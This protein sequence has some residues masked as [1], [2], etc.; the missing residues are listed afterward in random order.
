VHASR[1]SEHTTLIERCIDDS[2]NAIVVASILP[3]FQRPDILGISL[4][5]HHQEETP[6]GWMR[7]HISARA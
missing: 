5:V 7:L 3:P 4:T 6:Q 2:T 1:R